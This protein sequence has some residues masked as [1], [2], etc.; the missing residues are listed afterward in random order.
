MIT[1]VR[2]SFREVAGVVRAAGDGPRVHVDVRIP[3]V[4]IRTGAEWRDHLLCSRSFLDAAA[5]PTISFHGWRIHR[6][7]HG[8]FSIDGALTM[9]GRTHD[10]SVTVTAQ[11]HVIGEAR[12]LGSASFHATT[13]IDRRDFGLLAPRVF[14]MG[15][16]V[17]GRQMQIDMDLDLVLIEGGLATTPH[18]RQAEYVA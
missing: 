11:R 4:G 12:R 18:P 16:L 6:I 15:G 1:T 17:I 14:E 8:I 13:T 9:R 2:G 3:V 5:Y 10:I 7:R